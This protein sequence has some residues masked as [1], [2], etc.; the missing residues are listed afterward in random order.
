VIKGTTTGAVT[1]I[2]GKYSIKV[3][4][5]KIILVYS[6]VGYTPKEIELGAENIVDV[7]MQPSKTTLSEL[8]VVDM[9]PCV[10]W[11]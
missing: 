2:N 5:G 8:V 1:D 4:E 3:P 6:F 9:G 10:K 7:M 11:I